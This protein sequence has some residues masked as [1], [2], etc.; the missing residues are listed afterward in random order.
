MASFA[1]PL[2]QVV[3]KGIATTVWGQ[4]RPGTGTRTYVLQR[5]V[6]G[7][8][9]PVGVPGTTSARVYFTSTIRDDKGT[10][11]RLFDPDTSR[12]SPTLVVT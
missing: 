6:G 12:A 5:R 11:L 7:R 9:S 10:Q 4:V 3:R 2:A 1:L 8:W